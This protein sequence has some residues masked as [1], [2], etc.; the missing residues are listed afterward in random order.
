MNVL[1]LQIIEECQ[2]VAGFLRRSGRAVAYNL[3][4][5]EATVRGAE[6]GA[7]VVGDRIGPGIGGVETH[8]EGIGTTAPCGCAHDSL[9]LLPRQAVHS[10]ISLGNQRDREE[11]VTLAIYGETLAI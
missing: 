3:Q 5:V 7:V 10:V 11:E 1:E 4:I 6:A 9:T 8:A 2:A